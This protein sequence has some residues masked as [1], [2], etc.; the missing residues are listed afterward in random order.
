[1][2]IA[3]IGGS[4]KMGRWLANFLLKAGREVIITGRNRRKL[5]EAKQQ[6]GVEVATNVEAVK[7]ADVILLSVPI[8]DFE[9]VIK[10]ICPYIHPE[11]IIIDITSIKESP[12]E[13][14]HKH[15]KRGLTLGVHPMFGPGARDITNQN[16]VLTPTNKKERALAQKVREYLETRGARV[17]VMTPHQHDEMMS[18]ILG[19][20]HFI[21]IVSADTLLSLNKL[22]LMRS[23]S[24]STYKVW[25]TLVASVIS[26]N[27]EFCASLQMNLPSG[28]KVNRL[29]QSR[30]EAWADLVEN[31]DR[32]KFIRRMNMLRNRFEKVDADLPRAYQNMY[33]LI[34]EL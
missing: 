12:V 17:T 27:P 23:I 30:F 25:L 29:F 5:L 26:E 31:K 28:G 32:R 15:I 11:Q 21:A 4:G 24:G 20:S 34:E 9:E 14:M 7:K 8:D 22:K 18:V 13:I 33:K 19:L 16:F 3:I 10:Q 6:L 2:K 1:M